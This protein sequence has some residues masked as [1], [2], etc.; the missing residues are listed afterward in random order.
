[1]IANQLM[2][3]IYIIKPPQFAENYISLKAKI[4]E[5]VHLEV[6]LAKNKEEDAN[7]LKLLKPE[8]KLLEI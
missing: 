1:M 3:I 4:L 6:C 7:H 5:L 2:L 8:E